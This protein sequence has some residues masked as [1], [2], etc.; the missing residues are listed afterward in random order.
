MVKSW[1]FWALAF[2]WTFTVSELLT[3]V[4]GEQSEILWQKESSV[5]CSKEAFPEGNADKT[6]HVDISSPEWGHNRNI[7]IGYKYQKSVVMFKNEGM[8]DLYRS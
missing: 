1:D 5:R 2:M 4:G 7:K 3:L 6:K 8:T